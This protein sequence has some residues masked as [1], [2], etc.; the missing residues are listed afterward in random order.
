MTR[1]KFPKTIKKKLD[2]FEKLGKL[3]IKEQKKILTQSLSEI[4][5]KL[6]NLVKLTKKTRIPER[7]YGKLKRCKKCINNICKS[8]S[9]R[10][11]I[12][13]LTGGLLPAVIPLLLSVAGPVVSS[14]VDVLK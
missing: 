9:K 1:K 6:V 11:I 2:F 8:K 3:N 13:Q 12:K 4:T 14:I 7:F 10:R 5:N